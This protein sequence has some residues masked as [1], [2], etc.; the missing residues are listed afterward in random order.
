MWAT[1]EELEAQ[2]GSQV[3]ARRL[4][5]NRTVEDLAHAAG[6]AAKT[7]Q[8]LELGR[9]SSLG[10]LVKVLRALDAEAWLG[11]LT[12]PAAT[13]PVAILAAARR[14]APRQRASRSRA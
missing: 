2:L 10:T 14:G 11:T 12:P 7:L 3:R 1:V 13:S 6:I 9:G 4:A 8:N 5:A